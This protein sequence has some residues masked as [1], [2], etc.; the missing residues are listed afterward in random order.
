MNSGELTGEL[1]RRLGYNEKDTA[2]LVASLVETMTEQFQEGKSV[3]I[4]DFGS[5]DVEKTLEHITV[6]DTT[7]KRYLL[8]PS[9]NL[10]FKSVFNPDNK[11]KHT[12]DE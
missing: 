1:S 5:F 2:C 12:A 3:S 6:D 7:G 11:L 4:S 10:V 9:L 8:P